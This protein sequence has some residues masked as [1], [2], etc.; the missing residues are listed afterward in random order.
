MKDYECREFIADWKQVF[1]NG[2]KK[3][4]VIPGQCTGNRG[5]VIT[6]ETVLPDNIEKDRFLCFRSSKQDMKFYVDGKLRME[7]STGDTV[8]GY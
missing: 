6:I 3:D 8:S 5:D 4:V 1:P 7:Y 2:E